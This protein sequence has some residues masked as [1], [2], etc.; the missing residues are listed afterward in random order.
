MDLVRL[1]WRQRALVAVLVVVTGVELFFSYQLDNAIA[2]TQVELEA[3][4][5]ETNALIERY[6][7]Q[8]E[9]QALVEEVRQLEENLREKQEFLSFLEGRD[10]GNTGG[11][12][13]YLADLSRFH[14]AGLRLTSIRLNNGGSSVLLGGEV[15]Q[16]ENV[17]LYRASGATLQDQNQPQP[18]QQPQ[19]DQ[20][21]DSEDDEQD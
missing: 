8:N 3:A 12:S 7:D 4:R 20:Q 1:F 21:N 5:A 9:D 14:I 10:I 16:A 17:P 11:F 18:A 19:Q 13:E 15:S 6:G 2:D